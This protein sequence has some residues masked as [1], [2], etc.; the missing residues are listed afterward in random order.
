MTRYTVLILTIAG[1]AG[2]IN[3]PVEATRLLWKR[4]TTSA[5]DTPAAALS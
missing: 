1:L 4:R 5:G 3:L 2:L